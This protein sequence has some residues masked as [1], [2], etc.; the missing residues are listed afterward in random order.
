MLFG[1]DTTPLVDNYYNI[2]ISSVR[3]ALTTPYPAVNPT[4]EALERFVF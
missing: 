4:E 1:L 3:L 2:Y